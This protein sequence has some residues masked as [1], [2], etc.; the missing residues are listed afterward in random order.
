MNN[1]MVN[2][3]RGTVAKEPAIRETITELTGI[4]TMD[5]DVLTASD[6]PSFAITSSAISLQPFSFSTP[7]LPKL[8]IC[9]NCGAPLIKT[10]YGFKCEYCDSIY[11]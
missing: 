9:Q 10:P 4:L 5:T 1:Y 6:F 2:D 8:Q 11:A 3:G 7:S